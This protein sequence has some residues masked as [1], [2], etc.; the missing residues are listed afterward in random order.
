MNM[1]MFNR[2]KKTPHKKHCEPRAYADTLVLVPSSRGIPLSIACLRSRGSR[3]NTYRSN[4]GGNLWRTELPNGLP[5]IV[6]WSSREKP[7]QNKPLRGQPP[8]IGG[9]PYQKL[10]DECV[11]RSLLWIDLFGLAY[12]CAASLSTTSANNLANNLV[13]SL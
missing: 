10:Y 7:D 12:I 13:K 8:N 1:G 3:N 6:Q 11:R 5:C 4:E 2:R 9:R